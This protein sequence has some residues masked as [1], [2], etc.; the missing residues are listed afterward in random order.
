M[1]PRNIEI[2]SNNYRANAQRYFLDE[3]NLEKNF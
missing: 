1:M 2:T 3:T